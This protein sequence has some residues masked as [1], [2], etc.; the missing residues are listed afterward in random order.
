MSGLKP[1]FLLSGAKVPPFPSRNRRIG[2]FLK[3]LRL[4]EARGTGLPTIFRTM[5]SNGSPLP[6]FDFDDDRTYF[7]ATL[8]AHPEYVALAAL[9]E[10]AQLDATGNP[11]KALERLESAHQKLPGSGSLTAKLIEAYCAHEK[12][13]KARAVY[14]S[15]RTQTPRTSEAKVV[16]TLSRCYLSAGLEREARE[17]L[18]HLK[19]VSSAHDAIELAILERRARREDK[20]HRLFQRAEGSDALLSDPKALH[21]FAQCKLNLARKAHKTGQHRQHGRQVNKRLLGE[22]RELID[23][24][25]Q[26]EAHA[27][28]HARAWTDLAQILHYLREPKDQIFAALDRA[29]EM[30][31]D[32]H[33]ICERADQI[34]RS[35]TDSL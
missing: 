1:E 22:A 10:S 26:L 11:E 4:A 23:R 16:A 28:R 24:V 6:T 5:A 2:E 15:F 27:I 12:F 9:R 20:A 14:E 25:L 7:R 35:A 30:A 34:R 29:V 13:S 21:E 17:V 3:E 33:L 32:D 19:L 31:P 18:E 8:P